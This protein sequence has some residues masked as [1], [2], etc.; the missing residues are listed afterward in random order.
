MNKS[1]LSAVSHFLLLSLFFS[2][3]TFSNTACADTLLIKNITLIDPV[4]GE[5]PAQ[6]LLIEG[7]KIVQIASIGSLQNTAGIT[8]T[9]DGYGK[10]LIPCALGQSCSRYR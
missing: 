1:I 6:D 3:I 9:I 5:I 2:S 8:K 4:D 10:Y 7:D